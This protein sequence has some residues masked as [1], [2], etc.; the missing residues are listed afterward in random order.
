MGLSPPIPSESHCDGCFMLVGEGHETTELQL[1]VDAK[2]SH[3]GS[4][5][6]GDVRIQDMML[7]ESCYRPYA[8]GK[9]IRTTG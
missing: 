8:K 9:V 2:V 5:G 1:A 6:F 4:K 3:S 7:C